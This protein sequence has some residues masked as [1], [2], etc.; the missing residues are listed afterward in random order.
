MIFERGLEDHLF[1]IR[2]RL[3]SGQYRHGAY[4]PFVV[5]D[6]KRR[7]IHKASIQ[8]R[9]VHQALVNIIEPIFEL[10]FFH[11][12]YSC[13]LGKGTHAAVA[14]LQNFLREA[15]RN[16]TRTVYSLKCDVRK[17][18][19][20]VDHAVLFRLLEV[21]IA[22]PKILWLAR[23]IINSFSSSPGKGIPLGNITSQLFS[24]IY[25]HE[26]D[27]YFKQELRVRH[28]VRYCDD[29]IILLHSPCEAANMARQADDFLRRFLKI[30]L[31]PGKTRIRT[32]EQ[33]IDFL[34]YVLLPHATV[35]RPKT[36]DRMLEN[37]TVEN[38]ASYLGLCSHADAYELECTVRN[39]SAFIG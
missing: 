27:W 38:A 28:Y 22:D 8:D 29:F 3:V 9:V 33:G 18:F 34:G 15:S 4:E 35:L 2:D 1:E 10:R 37:V 39:K 36:A 19:D 16:D 24:N 25:L 20:S 13:R 32:W 23:Y 26:L 7:L 30:K 6:P 11:A 14:E 31:H 21:R 5:H 17:F 12:S